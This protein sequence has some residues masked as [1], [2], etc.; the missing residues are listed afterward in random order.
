MLDLGFEMS[1][2]VAA[3]KGRSLEQGIASGKRLFARLSLEVAPLGAGNSKTQVPSTYRPVGKTCPSSCPWL[4]NGCYAQQGHV[5]LVE[6]RSASEAL[7]SIRSA[8]L[9]MVVARHN[10]RLARLHVSGDFLEDGI[11][12]MAYVTGLLAVAAEIHRLL[13]GRE[14]LAWSYTHLS[15]EEFGVSHRE[16][17]AAGILVLWSEQHRD[18][19][20]VVWEHA[21]IQEL[22]K[23]HPELRYV[24]CRAQLQDE[25][26]CASCDLCAQAVSAERRL[27][28]VFDPHGAR[29]KA[30][31]DSL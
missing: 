1:D 3:T 20:A 29:Q 7:P 8:A 9:A 15:Q 25:V 4:D 16:L 5:R 30:V 6:K 11:V 14:E 21:R 23:A 28:I 27:T 2:L 19:G 26:S 18:G 31:R 24:K 13:P 10:K 17:Q 22:R 12:S